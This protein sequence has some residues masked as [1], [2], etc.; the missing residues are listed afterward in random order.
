MRVIDLGSV[1]YLFEIGRLSRVIGPFVVP[2]QIEFS[3]CI[4]QEN[5][6]EPKILL[7]Q[8]QL[9]MGCFLQQFGR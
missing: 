7:G 9:T 6:H 5:S 3:L 1:F 8:M 4:L 2:D